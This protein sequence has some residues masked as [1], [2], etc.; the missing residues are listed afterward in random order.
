MESDEFCGTTVFEINGLPDWKRCGDAWKWFNACVDSYGCEKV[1]NDAKFNYGKTNSRVGHRRARGG[2]PEYWEFKMWGN[3]GGID[4]TFYWKCPTKDAAIGMK[5]FHDAA[6]GGNLMET[7]EYCESNSPTVSLVP[8]TSPAPSEQPA[9]SC[10]RPYTAPRSTPFYLQRHVSTPPSGGNNFEVKKN[11]N[12][13]VSGAHAGGT[14]NFDTPEEWIEFSAPL[15]NGQLDDNGATLTGGVP[16]LSDFVVDGTVAKIKEGNGISDGDKTWQFG[17]NTESSAFIELFRNITR[18]APLVWETNPADDMKCGTTPDF[19]YDSKSYTSCYVDPVSENCGQY[20]FVIDGETDYVRDAKIVPWFKACVE[21]YGCEIQDGHKKLRGAGSSRVQYNGR[22]G[23]WE[24]KAHGPYWR[25]E[26]EEQAWAMKVFAD[27]VEAAALFKVPDGEC[28]SSPTMA[29]TMCTDGFLTQAPLNIAVV[30]EFRTVLTSRNLTELPSVILTRMVKKTPFWTQRLQPFLPY[31][32]RLL[33]P[34]S[35]TT[36]TPTL[37]S[38]CSTLKPTTRRQHT[39][40]RESMLH[41]NSTRTVVGS[42]TPSLSLISR[43]CRHS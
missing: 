9:P 16:A 35:W 8:S 30:I 36:T 25:C 33:A 15:F 41:S 28:T 19:C 20:D 34:R 38:F 22:S 7:N 23:K 13:R 3:G 4:G 40:P 1:Q 37:V 14:K 12:Y 39:R 17:T 6:K 10:A 26:T 29:P 27:A 43:V 5:D 42:Q 2:V 11:C 32:T 18:D 24:F 21:S 31:W